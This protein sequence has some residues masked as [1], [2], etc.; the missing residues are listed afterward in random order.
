MNSKN[1]KFKTG[2]DKSPKEGVYLLIAGHKVGPVSIEE[3]QDKLK[4]KEINLQ[5]LVSLDDGKNWQKIFEC[6]AFSRAF[7][8]HSSLP[9][10]PHKG[11]FFKS[12]KDAFLKVI[13]KEK[14]AEQSGETELLSIKEKVKNSSPHVNRDLENL[15]L[16]QEVKKR[17]IFNAF[18]LITIIA[19]LSLIV[20][21]YNYFK[22]LPKE[23][24][25]QRPNK[26]NILKGLTRKK[27]FR[28]ISRTKSRP[29]PVLDQ[30]EKELINEE[31]H[32]SSPSTYSRRESQYEKEDRKSPH[33]Y[34]DQYTD[35]P[36]DDYQLEAIEENLEL[37]Q[38]GI[39]TKEDI[40]GYRS[41]Q[42]QEKALIQKKKQ[43]LPKNDELIPMEEEY[44][45]NF[46]Y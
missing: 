12:N 35:Y 14:I 13:E 6:E 32:Y 9:Q 45:E 11:N 3:I 2:E 15:L 40:H 42:N 46:D 7:S 38:D 17:K 4:E 20:A 16:M 5:Q 21:N 28:I 31:S 26:E 39:L 30:D 19:T 44:L 29:K 22:K 10:L 34:E 41:G 8:P 27:E 1:Q 37:D 23:K 43:H 25:T 18:A 24:F 36:V 33:E